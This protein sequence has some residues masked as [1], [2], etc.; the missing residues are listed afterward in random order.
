LIRPLACLLGLQRSLAVLPAAEGG[1]VRKVLYILGKLQDADLQWLLEAGSVRSLAPGE[2]LIGEG[3]AIQSLY[4]VIEGELAVQRS[5]TELA[6][7]DVG[8]VVGEMSLLSSLPASATV[9]ALSACTVF[10]IPQTRLKSKLR[11]D[12]QFASR[13]HH[14]MCLFLVDRLNRTDALIGKGRRIEEARHAS[15]GKISEDSMDSVVL[16]GARFNWFLERV[17]G[18]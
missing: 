8:E 3:L 2:Q 16:A 11:S 6:R 14:A 4:I 18:R 13:F 15:G 12:V 7:L 17:R 5:G 10:E 1:C 9:S